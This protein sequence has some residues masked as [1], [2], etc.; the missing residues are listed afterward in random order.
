MSREKSSKVIF[1]TNVLISFLIGKKLLILK[2]LVV[3]RQ[4]IIILSDQLLL[5]LGT[6]MQHPKLA[7]YFP[8]HEAE[9]LIYF[10]QVIGQKYEAASFH[11]LSRDPKDN[12]LLDLADIAEADY[13]VTGDKDLLILNPFKV[14]RILTTSDF[15]NELNELSK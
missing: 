9:E 4:F 3:K 8:K 5:E 15:E 2:K 12:F 6:V 1:D 13:L 14:T 7:K 10:F 11:E